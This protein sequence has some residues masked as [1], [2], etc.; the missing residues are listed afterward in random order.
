MRGDE[1]RSKCPDIKLVQVP[2]VR[3]KADLTKYRNAG[4]E[5]IQVKYMKIFD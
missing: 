4:K 2:E 3:E 1:A 5:V